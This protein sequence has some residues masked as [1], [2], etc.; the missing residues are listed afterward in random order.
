MQEPVPSERAVEDPGPEF[1]STHAGTRGQ[2]LDDHHY[3]ASLHFG[4]ATFRLQLFTAPNRRP[5]AVATQAMGVGDGTSLM[6][7]GERIVEHVWHRHFP[8]DEQPPIWV[9]NQIL[10]SAPRNLKLVTFSV[11]SEG[12][13]SK[14]KW[15]GLSLEQL[16]RLTGNVIDLDRGDVA[17]APVDE[18]EDDYRYEVAEV[19]DAPP[20]QPFRV[21]DCMA[22]GSNR[23]RRLLWRARPRRLRQGC[24]WYHGGDWR[25]V[26][27]AAVRLLQS[28]QAVAST[29]EEVR[30]QVLDEADAEGISGWPGEALGSLF[31]DPIS[32]FDGDE[33]GQEQFINGQHR[34]QAMRDARVQRTVVVRREDDQ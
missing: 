25:V 17:E 12:Q 30:D 20:A 11:N 24:C 1:I 13:L 21:T 18:P 34:I 8:E 23:V 14:P 9:Q 10:G 3:R 7:A 22:T 5:V 27:E 33:T 2:T 16:H 15:R 28:A 4:T 31:M 32:W 19:D 6:N 26:N 29:S